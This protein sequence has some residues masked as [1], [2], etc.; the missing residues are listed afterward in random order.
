MFV[1]NPVGTGVSYADPDDPNA[2]VTNMSSMAI[3]FY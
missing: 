3:D 2:Y 1:D